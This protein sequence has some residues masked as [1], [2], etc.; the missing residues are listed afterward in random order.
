LAKVVALLTFGVTE[1]KLDRHLTTARPL[2]GRGF[3]MAFYHKK[4]KKTLSAKKKLCDMKPFAA[5][6]NPNTKNN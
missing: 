1:S 6:L 5:A 4:I 3:G 2:G